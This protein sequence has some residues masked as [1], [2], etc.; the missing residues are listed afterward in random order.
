ML[1]LGLRLAVDARTVCFVEREAPSAEI[2]AARMHDGL[3][4][5]APVWSDLTTFDGRPWRGLVDIVAGGI[6][7]Q[8]FSC[9]GKQLGNDDERALAPHLLRIVGECL[10]SVVFVEN[11]PPWVSRG[12]A[13]D[14]LVGLSDLGY[15]IA[16]P[17]FAT[18]S[19]FGAPHRRERVF[20][21]AYAKGPDKGLF[22]QRRR[23]LEDRDESRGRGED[24]GDAELPR[25]SEQFGRQSAFPFAWPP[26][27]SRDW[28]NIDPGFWPATEPRVRRMAN[29]HSSRVDRLR[30]CG[31]GVV[32]VVAA[33]AFRALM[34]TLR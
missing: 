24:V 13:R 2:L 11:V 3:L 33:Y 31:N 28:S 18:A 1:D 26:S 22:V 12:Y 15:G 6:P 34:E 8:P 27:R 32:P 25:S 17:F 23:S 19:A 30:A 14:L 5:D 29:G 10:P 4:D 9:A 16:D 20:V 21:M 7:C